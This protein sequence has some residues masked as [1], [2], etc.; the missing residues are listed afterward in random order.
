MSL[1]DSLHDPL[2]LTGQKLGPY[3][4]GD[5]ATAGGVALIYRGE[6]ETLH[7]QVAVKVLTPE[8]AMEAARPTLEA[9]F[10]REAQILSQL[11]SEDILRA[12]DLGRAV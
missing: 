2:E 5:I 3:I 12:H 1:S 4:V 7:N 10:M 8:V 9:L 6:H 11:R